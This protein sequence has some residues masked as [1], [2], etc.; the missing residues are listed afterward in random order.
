MVVPDHILVIGGNGFLGS[1]IVSELLAEKWPTKLKIS[2]LDIRK[3]AVA[4]DNV[5]Y[6]IGDITSEDDMRKAFEGVDLIIHTASPVHGLGRV[7]YF[8]VNVE[9]TRTII[10]VAK[11][12]GVSGM[13][14]TSSA[15]VVFNGGDLINVNE[16]APIPAVA[17]DAYNESKAVAEKL[18]L[19]SNS[20]EFRTCAIRPAGLFGEGDRQ[21]IPGMLSVLKNKQTRFQI[22]S[23]NNLFDFTYIGNAAFS[24]VLA[25]RKLLE[26]PVKSSEYKTSTGEQT[27]GVEGEAFFVSNGQPIYFWDF[28]RALYSYLNFKGHESYIVFPKNLAWYMGLASEYV[29]WILGKEPTFTRFRV[30]F[31][32]ANRY[33]DISKARTRLGYYPKVGLEEGM[34]RSLSWCKE[35]GELPIF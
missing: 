18:V 6:L 8:K 28:P 9:G 17:M 33:Y 34:K 29:S 19:D 7:V 31:S 32:C 3:P 26:S 12:V 13:V 11:Q 25:A 27:N 4:K 16:T 22:G 10:N 24:H 2:V 35:N 30:Q 5:T 23:N 20:S 15:G 1:H 14:Y 21:L